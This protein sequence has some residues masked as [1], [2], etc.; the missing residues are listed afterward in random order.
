MGLIDAKRHKVREPFDTDF[1]EVTPDDHYLIL[2]GHEEQVVW[3]GRPAAGV[4]AEVR[5]NFLDDKVLGRAVFPQVLLTEWHW[6]F[7][8]I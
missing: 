1:G 8:G 4:E 6:P 7:K 3:Q 2:T 5:R